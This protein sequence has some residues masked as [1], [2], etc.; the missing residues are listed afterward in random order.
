MG[1]TH[2]NDL[3]SLASDYGE[4]WI[5]VGS[6]TSLEDAT[7]DDT[8]EDGDDLEVLGT[9]NQ[10]EVL[11]CNVEGWKPELENRLTID[12]TPSEDESVEKLFSS[13]SEE[14]YEVV[15]ASEVDV[16][17][18]EVVKEKEIGDKVCDNKKVSKIEK[19][20]FVRNE[21]Y[22]T[23]HGKR[24]KNRNKKRTRKSWRKKS[25]QHKHR[26]KYAEKKGC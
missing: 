4:E 10:Y 8:G 14:E 7:V 11:S 5:E 18:A 26:I 16:V 1:S 23:V 20:N 24:K 13:D 21:F 19:C 9:A 17:K 2:R 6:G 22:D 3:E 15:K 12:L 25:P